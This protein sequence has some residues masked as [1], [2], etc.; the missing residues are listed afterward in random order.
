VLLLAG[1]ALLILG[2][3]GV[4]AGNSLGW[5]AIGIGALSVLMWAIVLV[6]RLVVAGSQKSKD[7]RRTE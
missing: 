1:V 2:I 3:A 6:V 5:V 4:A 7:G